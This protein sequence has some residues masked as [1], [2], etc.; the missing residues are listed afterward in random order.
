MLLITRIE[1]RGA[2]PRLKYLL[3][4]LALHVWLYVF[5]CLIG[6]SAVS[7]GAVIPWE[8]S[9]QQDIVG[10]VA[11]ALNE[12]HALILHE[13]APFT[14][15]GN[16]VIAIFLHGGIIHLLLN[17]LMLLIFG[18]LLTH[19]MSAVDFVVLYITAG[20]SGFL[21]HANLDPLSFVPVIG[22]SGAVFGVLG[23]YGLLFPKDRI[24]G[25]WFFVLPFNLSAREFTLVLLSVEILLLLLDNSRI[26]HAAHIGGFLAG[27]SYAFAW[28]KST[29]RDSKVT[30]AA[31]GE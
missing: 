11:I 9:E 21:F 6:P 12:R 3:G 19:R 10:E 22:A 23:A 17:M 8:L 27:T 31:S 20:V 16:L 24:R 1:H 30:A 7:S 26:S 18:S 28:Q 5:Q 2:R 13:A 25:L 14:V 29:M 15:N 4:L